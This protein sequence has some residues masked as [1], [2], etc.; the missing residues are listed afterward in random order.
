LRIADLA[1]RVR[2]QRVVVS[3]QRIRR[4]FP[5]PAERADLDAIAG[6]AD[7]LEFRKPVDVD[8]RSAGPAEAS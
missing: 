6:F 3:E 2:K 4:E 8:R 7:V 1:A 5:D